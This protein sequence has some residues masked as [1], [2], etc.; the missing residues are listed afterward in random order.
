MVRAIVEGIDKP[1][2]VPTPEREILPFARVY[3]PGGEHEDILIKL[4]HKN[5]Y[6]LDDGGKIRGI[7]RAILD[8]GFDITPNTELSFT[9]FTPQE[10]AVMHG[11]LELQE[12]KI[13]HG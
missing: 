5:G 7:T 1:L 9:S 8:R 4:T 6:E 3:F 10:V 12:R 11:E 2:L 13:E